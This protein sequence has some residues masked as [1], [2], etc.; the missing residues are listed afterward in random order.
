MF[1]LFVYQPV[2]FLIPRFQVN[3]KFK[4][5]ASSG[6]FWKRLCLDF[7][8]D[9]FLQWNSH[10]IQMGSYKSNPRPLSRNRHDRHVE[11]FITPLL[12]TRTGLPKSPK[13]IE[14]WFKI[15]HWSLGKHK[16]V[17]GSWRVTFMHSFHFD[18]KCKQRIAL[19]SIFRPSA[20]STHSLDSI[21]GDKIARIRYKDSFSDKRV[22]VESSGDRHN[23][24]L[25][26]DN[27]VRSPISHICYR[28]G[29]PVVTCFCASLPLELLPNANYIDIVVLIHPKCR[30][31]IGTVQVLTKV[32][33]SCKLFCD[34]DFST[35]GRCKN[36]DQIFDDNQECLNL[37]LYP[38]KSSIDVDCLPE[39][40]DLTLGTRC[41][42]SKY[43]RTRIFVIDGSWHQ[44]K[45]IYRW[46]PRLQSLLQIHIKPTVPTIYAK[47]K[48]EPKESYVC[49]AE[50]V[51][52]AMD[53]LDMLSGATSRISNL[54]H[55][56]SITETVMKP[57]ECII[58]HQQ[59]FY[60][61]HGDD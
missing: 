33:Q 11:K 5:L 15:D 1:N 14:E 27:N 8:P 26:S 23:A 55:P 31:S 45:Y 21:N 29:R 38:S 49:T 46:N 50:A 6:F 58:N 53:S 24:S 7:W 52:M 43:S 48:R 25:K 32:F 61:L 41:S 2:I 30:T 44:A 36:L 18:F 9:R 51:A 22:F 19:P 40:V 34:Y 4:V 3:K 56:A 57:V 28:C 13:D 35:R 39:F 42:T 47:L 20:G 12:D 17:S 10:D 54:L 60:K 16:N 37:L 59:R